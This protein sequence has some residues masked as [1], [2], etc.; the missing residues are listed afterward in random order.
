MSLACN[1]IGDEFQFSQFSP[2]THSTAFT[3]QW[4]FSALSRKKLTKSHQDKK[5]I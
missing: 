2:M 5:I 4:K 3:V 1:W